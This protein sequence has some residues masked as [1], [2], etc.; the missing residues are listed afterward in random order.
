MCRGCSNMHGGHRSHVTK[1]KELIVKKSI[2]KWIAIA[3]VMASGQAFAAA[4]DDAW[5][6]KCVKDNAKEGAKD[7]VVEKYCICMNGKMDANETKSITEWEKTH[8]DEMKA[9]EKIAG[10]K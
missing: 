6:A 3:A 8:P 5:I 4:D 7:E 2:I 1:L 9:C 10:W